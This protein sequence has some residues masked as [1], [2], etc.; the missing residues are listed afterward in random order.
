[1]MFPHATWSEYCFRNLRLVSAHPTARQKY[2]ELLT[3][4]LH[5]IPHQLIFLEALSLPVQTLNACSNLMCGVNV[6][7]C[8]SDLKKLRA[9]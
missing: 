5:F 8:E 3:Y 6:G 1:M 2:S 9:D 7:P 4:S